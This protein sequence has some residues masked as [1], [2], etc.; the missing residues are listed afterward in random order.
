M[1]LTQL[2]LLAAGV[3]RFGRGRFG[4]AWGVVVGS[5]VVGVEDTLPSSWFPFTVGSVV[6]GRSVL[7]VSLGGP[8]LGGV[9]TEEVE[10]SEEE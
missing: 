2:G 10:A 9:G 5:D 8:G 3:R 6:E 4:L 1:G 7:R